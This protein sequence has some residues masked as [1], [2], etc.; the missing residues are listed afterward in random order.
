MKEYWLVI[1]SERDFFI[2]YRRVHYNS[3]SYK[4]VAHSKTEAI[5]KAL[6][7]LYNDCAPV[8]GLTVFDRMPEMQEPDTELILRQ[9]AT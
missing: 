9:G 1:M 8:D 5:A 2:T 3:P 4:I 7:Y 6:Y